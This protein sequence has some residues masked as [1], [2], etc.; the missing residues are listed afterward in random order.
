VGF[1]EE[2]VN[3][4]VLA[5]ALRLQGETSIR[6]GRPADA[7]TALDRALTVAQ[8]F[9][10]PAEIAGVLCSQASVAYEQLRLDDARSVA[11]RAI[12]VS[13]LPHPMRLVPP[14]WV[15]GA[16]AL[17]TGDLDAA[18]RDFESSRTVVGHGQIPRFTANGTFGLAGVEAAR[19]RRA[20]AAAAH[21]TA[22]RLRHGMGD[23]LGVA[24][25]LLAVAT[26][27]L[28]DEPA[29]ASRLIGAA[30]ALRA[31]GGALP[32]P[33][34]ESDLADAVRENPAAQDPPLS[35]DRAVELALDLTERFAPG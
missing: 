34:Q 2:F 23:R 28:P 14:V 35:Q 3:R 21:G 20:A 17:R 13:G 11:D 26:V 4:R 27:V 19:G 18:A 7:L 1:A 15:R 31:A 25:S 32:T 10:A 12:G 29:E 9:G 24:E 16:V 30:T 22:L 5:H 6:R 33:R 8:E